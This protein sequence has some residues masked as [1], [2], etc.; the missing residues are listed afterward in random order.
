MGL[1]K[2]CGTGIS[3]GTFNINN[4]NVNADSIIGKLADDMKIGVV[5]D[6]EEDNIGRQNEIDQLG[7]A[8]TGH[9]V[10]LVIG[11]QAATFYNADR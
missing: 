5:G 2:W 3:A 1:A 10:P 6:I 11:A 8:I 7:R 4:P 9:D